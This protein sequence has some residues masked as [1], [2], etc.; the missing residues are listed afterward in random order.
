MGTAV[1]FVSAQPR[2]ELVNSFTR[3]FDNAVATARTCYSGKGIV[4]VEQVGADNE[5]DPGTK[6]EKLAR[7]DELAATLYQAGHHTVFQHAHFQFALSNISRQFAWTFLHSHPFYNSEQVSQRYVEVKPDLYVVPALGGESQA[8]YE[9]TLQRQYDAYHRLTELLMPIVS[10]EY[11]ARFRAR[12][13]QRD[14]WDK[15]VKKKALEIARYVLPIATFT[16]MYHTVSGI[17]LLRYWR[18]CETFD[19]PTEQRLVVGMMVEALLRVA[20]EYETILRE[21]IPLEETPEFAFYHPER[22]KKPQLDFGIA[23]QA[24]PSGG[25]VEFRREFDAELGGRVSKL[26]DWKQ[27]NELVLADSVREVFGVTRAQLNDDEAIELAL[28]PSQNRLLGDELNLSTM[29]KLTR[30]MVHPC[31]TFRKKLSH[32]GDSQDQR[33]RM[34]PASRPCLNAYLTSEPDV[35]TPDIVRMDS[36]V[37]KAYAEAMEMSWDAINQLR[38]RG[39]SDEFAAYLLPNAVAIRFTESGDLMSLHHKHAMR[40][41]Y[42]AQEEIWRASKDE[43]EQI[44]EINPRI[45]RWLL[46]PCGHRSVAGSSPICP[47]GARFCG[48][49]VWKLDLAQ[50][51]RVI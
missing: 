33:H 8:I 2:V 30:S 23:P 12:V 38:R 39:V 45:G 22:A 17:T 31:Y 5:P 50:Y 34:T 27:R 7:R 10:R 11:Y 47:E 20:P 24:G 9:R 43:A 3:P 18:L 26:V 28:N 44:R 1:K 32:T 6:A 35:I 16:Y 4:T 49:T 37:E 29:S 40:L 15:E 42:N 51:K 21:P 19:A 25:G 36:A 48:I 46:P 41:C 14:K 13:T